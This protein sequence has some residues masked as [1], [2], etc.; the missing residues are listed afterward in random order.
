MNPPPIF[1]LGT[2]VVRVIKKY[3]R[4]HGRQF[5]SRTEPRS[6]LNRCQI[7]PSDIFTVWFLVYDRTGQSVVQFGVCGPA[8][9]D[10]RRDVTVHLLLRA[11]VL[12]ERPGNHV[13]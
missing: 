7:A 11:V 2:P 10:V 5:A 12:G 13:T 6:D 4:Q 3:I 9:C 8:A 1:P